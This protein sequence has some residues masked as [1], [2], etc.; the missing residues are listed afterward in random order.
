MSTI[1]NCVAQIINM[2]KWR[3]DIVLQSSIVRQKNSDFAYE[4]LVTSLSGLNSYDMHEIIF[5]R[6]CFDH[7]SKGPF[8]G[9]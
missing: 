1:L 7:L 6:M 5:A 4:S 2:N 8:S 9:N 3:L